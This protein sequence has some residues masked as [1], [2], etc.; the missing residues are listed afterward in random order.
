M[1]FRAAVR[2]PNPSASSSAISVGP[3]VIS[4]R[5]ATA[6]CAVSLLSLSGTDGCQQKANDTLVSTPTRRPLSQLA[7]FLSSV[8]GVLL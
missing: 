8:T 7:L 2:G 5:V 1:A 4:E 6:P 3:G